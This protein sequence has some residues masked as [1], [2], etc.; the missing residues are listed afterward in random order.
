MTAS[1]RRRPGQSNAD[2]AR[3]DPN[4]EFVATQSVY[5]GGD[6]SFLYRGLRGFLSW[7]DRRRNRTPR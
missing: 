7:L 3:T 2:H 6:P 1:P 5:G 4:A